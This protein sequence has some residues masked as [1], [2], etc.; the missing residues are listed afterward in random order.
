M[1]IKSYILIDDWIIK[2]PD[3]FAPT[4]RAIRRLCEMAGLDPAPRDGGTSIA[5]RA[6]GSVDLS[7]ALEAFA[8]I[9]QRVLD[10]AEKVGKS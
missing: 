9:A 2:Q 6:E 3:N 5:S 8:I 10:A 7:A 1:T 4:V